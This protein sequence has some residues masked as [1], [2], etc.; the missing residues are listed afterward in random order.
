[1]KVVHVTASERTGA[2]KAASRL[3]DSLLRINVDSK[4]LV[5]DSP[6]GTGIVSATQSAFEKISSKLRNRLDEM[7]RWV[8]PQRQKAWWSASCIPTKIARRITALQP[9]VVNLHWTNGGFLSIQD[10]ATIRVPIVWTMHDMWPFTG[11]CHYSGTCRHYEK[12]CGACPQLGSTSTYDLSRWVHRQKSR[13]FPQLDLTLLSPSR[14][15]ANRARTSSL[16]K[17]REIIPIPNGIDLTIYKPFDK[18]ISRD[19]L[20][21]PKERQLILIGAMSFESDSRKGLPNFQAAVQSLSK[22][23]GAAAQAIVTFGGRKP[24]REM[25]GS[26]GRID[27]HDLGVLSDEVAMHLAYSACD[28]FVAPSVEDN[29]P[30]TI[31]EAAACGR[32]AV[33]FSIGGIPEIIEHRKSGYLAQPFDS[34]DLANGIIWCLE[35]SSRLE[36][37]SDQARKR[38]EAEFDSALQARRYLSVFESV[39]LKGGAK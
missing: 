30:N 12:L 7:L 26:I 11:G 29:L 17:D 37:L 34:E 16:F 25:L 14:W 35:D 23:P 24:I 22:R 9:D 39:C 33:A 2:G 13:H 27:C 28:V 32:P 19:L 1:M 4:M 18:T 38:A 8:Y 31:V 5:Q 6:G 36:S 20:G 15:L 21:L 10:L 3:H